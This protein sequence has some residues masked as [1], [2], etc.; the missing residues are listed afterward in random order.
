MIKNIKFTNMKIVIL[1]AHSVNP[2]DLSWEGLRQL[3][4]VCVYDRT[5]DNE[6]I[7]R[8]DGAEIVLT[9]KVVFN[10]NTIS[11]L[12]HLKYIGV[13]ATGYNVVDITAA[14]RHGITVTN[15][16][17]YS[18]DSV[19]Q[20]TFAHILNLTNKVAHYAT[21]NRQGAWGK[22]QDFCYWDTPLRELASL[23]LGIVGLGNIG[24]KVAAIAKD[25]GMDVYACTSKNSA[26]LPE[27]IQK[28]TFDG[29]LGVSDI[30]TLHCPLTEKTKGI[31]SREAINKMKRGS[32]LINTSR[33]PLV[34]EKAVAEALH[35]GQLSGYGADVMCEEP[36]S[37]DNPLF[38]APNASMTPHIAWATP[39]AR[40]RLIAIATDNVK[41]FINGTPVNIVN[42]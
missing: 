30:L 7:E 12:T 17:A 11:R 34:D 27:G 32:M 22:S 4:E 29:L 15:I 19:V 28:T 14:T 1:D 8:A 6:T 23:T 42:R 21:A 31:I 20:M 9:G 40:A 36:P 37:D 2:G 39:E 3:G 10:E 25:F 26:D 16:P 38:S 18:T 35:T 33:G 41:A 24:R 5:L 13:M